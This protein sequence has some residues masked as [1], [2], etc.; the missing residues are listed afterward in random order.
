MGSNIAASRASA[1]TRLAWSNLAAQAAEQ[2]GLAAALLV[3][4]LGLGAGEGAVGILQTTQT[5][6]FLVM[7]IPAGVLADRMSRARLM[8]WA[9]TLRVV[10]FVA[11]LAL[12]I[13]G[14]LTLSG[15]AVLGFLGACG[16]VAYSV[17]A[18]ALV[19][20]LVQSEALAAANPQGRSPGSAGVAAEV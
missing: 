11:V 12:M 17:S 13:G 8:A 7:A 16:T 14:M 18:P 10:S 15:L 5:L 2:V 3:A 1:F 19:P 4:V 9:E 20:A 6:P